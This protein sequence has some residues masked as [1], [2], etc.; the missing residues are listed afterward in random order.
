MAVIKSDLT[1]VTTAPD[2]YNDPSEYY[3]FVVE[4]NCREQV[5]LSFACSIS[6][7]TIGHT[8]TFSHLNTRHLNER[9]GTIFVYISALIKWLADATDAEVI[10]VARSARINDG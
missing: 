6:G 3:N 4:L 8:T 7:R 10:K 2:C 9:Y 1:Y 5:P